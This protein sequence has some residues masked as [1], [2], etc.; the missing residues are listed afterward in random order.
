M[1]V[2][3]DGWPTDPRERLR[4]RLERFFLTNAPHEM[5][6]V[7][8]LMSLGNAQEDEVM[9]QLY[10]K[11]GVNEFGEPM[12]ADEADDDV[13]DR[14]AEFYEERV[15]A[16][17]VAALTRQALD[18]NLPSDTLLQLLHERYH[19]VK[20]VPNE[21]RKRL[22][23]VFRRV[24]EANPEDNVRRVMT[25]KRREELSEDDVI[26]AV[27]DRFNVRLDGWPHST[28]ERVR[29]RLRLFFRHNDPARLPEVD[30]LANNIGD[31]SKAEKAF[32]ARLF[33][34]EYPGSDEFGPKDEPEVNESP[35]HSPASLSLGIAASHSL[36][37]TAAPSPAAI[38]E[39]QDMDDK[40][41][42]YMPGMTQVWPPPDVNTAE[43]LYRSAF[44]E[45][46]VRK[47]GGSQV[48]YAAPVE[49]P[50]ARLAR[51]FD[52]PHD[53]PPAEQHAV[54][55]GAK[56]RS[57]Q[58]RT[59]ATI[60]TTSEEDAYKK[61][62]LGSFACSTLRHGALPLEE[63]AV[64]K[65][66]TAPG[67]TLEACRDD[68][69]RSAAAQR[70]TSQHL[71]SDGG[72]LDFIEQELGPAAVDNRAHHAS[73]PRCKYTVAIPDGLLPTM[74]DI[75]RARVAAAAS[76]GADRALPPR[77]A[78]REEPL[79][80][81]DEQKHDARYPLSSRV[82]ATPAVHRVDIGR[83]PPRNL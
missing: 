11:Y 72:R 80:V 54:H 43:S 15:P 12:G 21:L 81:A 2:G 39:Q 23:T 50:F 7:E 75:D 62:K 67:R 33:E 46:L 44:F 48:E 68:R 58:T 18:Y 79:W 9:R 71:R 19:G 41:G 61:P 65:L 45:G 77:L 42:A 36:P 1:S 55:L 70:L 73:S 57:K 10:A 37:L 78:P 76:R 5:L 31:D 35:H 59:E 26:A 66:A 60:W 74:Q 63:N 49:D 17:E 51:Q 14:V 24:G 29:L 28:A 34:E 47:Y 20:A 25:L 16:D 64:R 8:R 3:E 69:R 52:D 30:D 38:S 27:A 4:R 13:E 40:G 53:Y 6:K 82:P 83:R 22:K 32:F 56:A